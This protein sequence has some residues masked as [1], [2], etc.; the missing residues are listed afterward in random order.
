[1]P[2]SIAKLRQAVQA[3]R[4]Q[5]PAGELT[6]ASVERLLD[7][8]EAVCAGAGSPD[9][10]ARTGA[11]RENKRQEARRKWAQIAQQNAGEEREPT[12]ASE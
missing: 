5:M 4:T 9:T 8:A 1:M 11:P 3:V 12:A 6:R 10:V 7:A 2:D